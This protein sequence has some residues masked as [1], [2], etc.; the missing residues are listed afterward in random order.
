[1]AKKQITNKEA[2]DMVMSILK[3]R[4]GNVT[5]MEEYF[6]DKSK[7]FLK[8]LEKDINNKKSKNEN[9]LRKK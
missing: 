9:T 8:K 4:W 7:E 3:D 2:L 1:M 6:V 5:D